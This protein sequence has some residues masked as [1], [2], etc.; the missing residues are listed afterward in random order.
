MRALFG[1]FTLDDS[2]RQL[3]A[4]R[5]EIH[6]SPKAF[7]LLS[8]LIEARP[9]VIAKGDLH[10]R[11]WPSTFVSEGGLASVIAELRAALGDD[12]REPRFIRTVFAFGYSFCAEVRTERS[13][14]NEMAAVAPVPV[15][16]RRAG[17]ILLVLTALGSAAL[18]RSYVKPLEAV[19]PRIHS[20]AILPF[21]TAGSDRG[22]EH[23]G[24][25]LTDVLITRMSCLRQ[26]MIRPTSAVAKYAPEGR[27]SVRVGREL[28]VEA[29]LEGNVRRSGDRIRVTVQLVNV[30]NRQPIWG[31]KFDDKAADIFSLED[32]ISEKVSESLTVQLNHFEKEGLSKR[33]TESATAY[34][35]Y[36]KGRYFLYTVTPDPWRRK[37]A[38]KKG[39]EYLRQAV[40]EDSTFALA[41]ASLAHA[42]GAQAIY[43]DAPAP[44]LWVKSAAAARRSLQLDDNLSEAH[45]AVGMV[46]HCLNRNWTVAE[47]ELRRALELNPNNILANRHYAWLLQ[48]LGRFD[49]AIPLRERAIELDPSDL[50][51]WREAGWTYYLARRYDEAIQRYET[52]LQMDPTFIA[53][54]RGLSDVYDQK[55]MYDKAIASGTKALELQERGGTVAWLGYHY[56]RSGNIRKAE[57][58]LKRL[59]E[60]AKREYVSPYHV[61]ILYTGLGRT[62]EALAWLGKAYSEQTGANNALVEPAFDP[63]RNDPRFVDLMR[64]AGF[65]KL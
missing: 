6:L 49:E 11:L 32:S 1:E 29:I 9:K 56:A 24:L 36:V 44:D 37:D 53:A 16:R 27:D 55:G 21:N 62:D 8:I 4:W 31:G 22:N 43:Q 25:G 48:N 52:L 39:L 65:N 51:S 18:S 34:E 17:R 5:G 23:L 35:M 3:T 46:E 19:A 45:C 64:R 54:Y 60:L 57:E 15:A 50:S 7:Q 41:F 12:A 40:A 61:A 63:L 33:Y 28:G 38:R 10:E 47:K 58:L 42:Y 14:E 30:A 2:T 20:I 13:R 26:V 59:N